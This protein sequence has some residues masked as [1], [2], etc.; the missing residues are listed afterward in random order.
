MSLDRMLPFETSLHGSNE[1]LNW[2]WQGRVLLQ[3][4]EVEANIGEFQHNC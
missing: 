3:D 4:G 1:G 2:N